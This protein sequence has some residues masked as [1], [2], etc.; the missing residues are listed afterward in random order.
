MCLDLHPRSS[1]HRT[2]TFIMCLFLCQAHTEN[3]QFNCFLVEMSSL[4]Q[5]CIFKVG[6]L[7]GSRNLPS[8]FCWQEHCSHPVKARLFHSLIHIGKQFGCWFYL[9]YSQF[10]SPASGFSEESLCLDPLPKSSSPRT[11][12][13]MM[14]CMVIQLN[15]EQPV[16]PT[17]CVKRLLTQVGNFSTE[18]LQG[19]MLHRNL[20][21]GV[22]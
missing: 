6:T 5:V 10:L 17:C 8:E 11:L 15:R 21:I 7:H 4:S 19:S 13:L 22:F 3:S 12:S 9:G 2:P 18:T 20:G 1:S 16:H 14:L